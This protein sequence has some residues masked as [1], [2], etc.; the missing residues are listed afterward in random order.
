MD[1]GLSLIPLN[2]QCFI[3]IG[4]GGGGLGG[5]HP[6]EYKEGVGP[7]FGL[8]LFLYFS[9]QRDNRK[10]C[11]LTHKGLMFLGDSF[12]LKSLLLKYLLWNRSCVVC[13]F[14]FLVLNN[15]LLYKGI[16]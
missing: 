10:F 5:G 15:L 4:G 16:I 2:T 1:E 12:K 7:N 11:R 14:S 13:F 9:S 8:L 3:I 6:G